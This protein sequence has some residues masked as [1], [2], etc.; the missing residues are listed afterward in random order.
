MYTNTKTWVCNAYRHCPSS[1]V[2]LGMHFFSGTAAIFPKINPQ[3][4]HTSKD[5]TGQ[6]CPSHQWT[7]PQ[8]LSIHI[9][10]QVYILHTVKLSVFPTLSFI[11]HLQVSAPH[12]LQWHNFLQ[13][14]HNMVLH[15]N[16]MQ[17]LHADGSPCDD[18]Q[19]LVIPSSIPIL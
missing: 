3:E 14:R 5:S 8:S 1:R 9:F 18:Q 2:I 7:L 16:R 17:F 12:A 4:K 13:A 6:K 19:F 10:I 11:G 15:R